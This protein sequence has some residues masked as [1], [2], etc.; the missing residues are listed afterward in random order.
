MTRL[1]PYRKAVVAFLV[2]GLAVAYTA[3]ADDVITAQE[4]VGIA[5]G[6]LGTPAAT[7]AVPNE[8]S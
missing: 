2:G 7:Y 6:A 1:A 5:L 8:P 4:W 3:L